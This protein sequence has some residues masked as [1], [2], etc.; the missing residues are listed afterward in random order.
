MACTKSIHRLCMYMSFS[1]IQRRVA[2]LRLFAK[3]SGFNDIRPLSYNAAH[4]GSALNFGP[5]TKLM[6]DLQQKCGMHA[7]HDQ[8]QPFRMTNAQ[9]CLFQHLR[10]EHNGNLPV[11]QK[12]R[13]VFI[14]LLYGLFHVPLEKIFCANYD[15]VAFS[16]DKDLRCQMHFRIRTREIGS[17]FH[18]ANSDF[19]IGFDLLRDIQTYCY[20]IKRLHYN[21]VFIRILWEKNYSQSATYLK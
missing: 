3:A 7:R 6:L 20:E 18:L 15:D 12:H 21:G 5:F 13:N 19:D 2:T 1:E 10:A 9:S 16:V 8:H 4:C 11:V 14:G 17:D